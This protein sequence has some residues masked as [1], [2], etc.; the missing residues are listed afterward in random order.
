M[1]RLLS[2]LLATALLAPATASAAV[3]TVEALYGLARP[4]SA[5]LTTAIEGAR[6]ERDLSDSS[7]QL[8]GGDVIVNLGGMQFGAIVDTTFGDGVTQ[9][10]LGGLFGFRLGDQLRLDLLGE[11]GGHRFGNV[12]DDRSIVTASSSS[13][14]LLYVGVRPGVAYR[15]DLGP[16]SAGIVVGVW[17]FARWDVTDSDVGVTVGDASGASPANVELGGTTIGAT[18][19]LG[20]EL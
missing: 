4:P 6:N 3:V 14:W 8:A 9:T 20:L 5:N 13:E 2:A 7:L 15:F 10:A 19:R 1:T 12:L 16:S 11:A 18:L 17:G